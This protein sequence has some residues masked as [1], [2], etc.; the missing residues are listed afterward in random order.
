MKLKQNIIT[1][2]IDGAQYMIPVGAEAFSGVVRNNETAAFLVTLL[3]E[4]TTEEALVDAMCAEYDASR[5]LIEKDVARVLATLRE[6]N[7]LEET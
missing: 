1:Q 3:R 6:L 4:E 7:A 2:E 5:A